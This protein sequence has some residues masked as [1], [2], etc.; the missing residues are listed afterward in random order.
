MEEAKFKQKT[1]TLK[2]KICVSIFSFIFFLILL[3]IILRVIGHFYLLGRIAPDQIYSRLRKEK[4]AH[5]ILCVGDSF[6][7]GGDLPFEFSYPFQLEKIL[8]SS[9][10]DKILTVINAGVCERNSAQVLRSLPKNI[11]YYHP[12]TVIL[13]VGASN[14]FNFIGFNNKQKTFYSRLKDFL[15]DLRVFK[16]AKIMALNLEQRIIIMK[17]REKVTPKSYKFLCDYYSF[18]P[19]ISPNIP[20]IKEMAENRLKRVDCL[21]EIGEKEEALQL[22]KKIMKIDPNSDLFIYQISDFLEHVNRTMG[23]SEEE[24]K[25]YDPNL[26]M[27]DFLKWIENNQKDKLLNEYFLF[28]QSIQKSYKNEEIKNR[29][30]EDLE[31]IVDIC[32]KNNIKLIVQDYPFPY[33]MADIA[34]RD[35]AAEH[36]LPLVRNS[37]VFSEL[38]AKERKEAYFLTDTHCTPLGYQIMAENIYKVIFSE[39]IFSELPGKEGQ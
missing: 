18:R 39:N 37:K 11:K 29:L 6:T 25:K 38:L 31:E 10:P 5:I 22:F 20:I 3:E 4:G 1:I 34:L 30:R 2:K 19:V 35:I 7:F 24:Q 15:Y 23:F 12:D 27:A 28:F 13:L 9:N 8:S 21:R 26:V 32:R 33:P 36:S 16:M 17:F 14:W